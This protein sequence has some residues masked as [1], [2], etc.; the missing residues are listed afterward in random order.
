MQF[1]WKLI[2]EDIIN[3]HSAKSISDGKIAAEIGVTKEAVRKLRC[4]LT[5]E[6]RYSTGLK[7]LTLHR[8]MCPELYTQANLD[9]VCLG[10]Q[11]EKRQKRL[12]YFKAYL[13]C[14]K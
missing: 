14:T 7:L 13:T 10:E 12:E 2:I 4:G 1:K 3:T 5:E 9:D 8:K 11:N 6:P